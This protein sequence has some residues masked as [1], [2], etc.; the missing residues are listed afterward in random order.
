MNATSVAFRQLVQQLAAA[1]RADEPVLIL[2]EVGTGKRQ[3]A[4]AIH[5]ASY[6][7]VNRFVT[8]NCMGL[9]DDRFLLELCGSISSGFEQNRKG[10]LYMAEGGTLYLHEIG[11][12]SLSSQAQLSRFLESQAFTP[13]NSYDEVFA[14][15]RI[16]ASSAV[17]LE[18]MVEAGRFRNDLFHHLNAITVR[19]PSLND[20]LQDM[21]MLVE[22]ILRD[23]GAQRR[24]SSEAIEQLLVHKFN[25]N[26]LELKNIVFRCLLTFNEEV[27]GGEHIRFAIRMGSQA[28]DSVTQLGLE[29]AQQNLGK[30]MHEEVSKIAGN[31]PVFSL[32][33]QGGAERSLSTVAAESTES[34]VKPK[35]SRLGAPSPQTADASGSFMAAA[36]SLDRPTTIAQ[37][38]AEHE[39]VSIVTAEAPAAVAKR[40]NPSPV[41]SSRASSTSQGGGF[42]PK[43]IKQQE[44]D[45]LKNLLA[46]CKGDK[47]LAAKLAGLSLRTFYRRLQIL[48]EA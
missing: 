14:N 11:E 4:V 41:E 33:H 2:G 6:R 7:S 40:A 31:G 8:I 29:Q 22:S 46:H 28:S 17:K 13:V 18:S 43:S 23:L 19:T 26:L 27:I 38:R 36:A 21:P 35:I 24:F 42:E 9:S 39:D 25:G 37:M 30:F 32:S 48:A 12:L 5:R 34:M 47:S 1:S 44:I 10:A 16:I 3:S 20:R 15:V 45:Y